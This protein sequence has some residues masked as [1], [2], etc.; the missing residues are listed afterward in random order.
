MH[1]TGFDLFPY[2]L[3]LAEPYV[4][5]RGRLDRREMILLRI[6]TD[7]GATGLGEAVPL[8]LR[9]GA[10]LADLDRSLR[11]A[12]ARLEG[13]DIGAMAEEPHL[14][15][16]VDLLVQITAGHDLPLPAMA[17]IEVALFDLA[18]RISGMPLWR[19]LRAERCEPVT[20]NAT[21]PAGPPAA[22]AAAAERWAGRGFATFKLKLGTER[23]AEQ[24][25]AV[26]ETVGT[27]ARLRVDANGAWSVGDAI[28]ALR[29]ID[30]LGIELAEQPTA[31]LAEMAEV[32]RAVEIPVAGDESITSAPE[33]AAARKEN[34]CELATAK[35]AKVG[36]IGA[37][38]AIAGE[39][40]TYLSS[41]LDGPVGIAA[42]AH[43]R[44]AIYRDRTD[45]GLAHGLATQLLFSE[46][47]ASR[48]C[49]VRDGALHLPGGPGLGVEIDETALE[50]CRI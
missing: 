2:A 15:A 29:E 41:A 30:P 43:A 19:L 20:C 34:A 42:A 49:E 24:V 23:D 13:T 32:A 22:V 37:A 17:A 11:R 47:I 1:I 3:P 45:P 5:A 6:R 36:G 38:N 21:L 33:A 10:T 9:G 25:A 26:R 40:P 8:A 44:Q 35:L 48:E 39:L 46:T 18:G 28:A 7:E 31:T 14:G 50:R 12:C 4:T 16:A 27:G